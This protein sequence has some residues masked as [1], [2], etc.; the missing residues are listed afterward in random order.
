MGGTQ[1]GNMVWLYNIIQTYGLLDFAKERYSALENNISTWDYNKT[2]ID[3]LKGKQPSWGWMPGCAYDPTRIDYYIDELKDLVPSKENLDM[4]L[5][6]IA[7]VH[8]H[9]SKKKKDV[10]VS[11]S[12]SSDGNGNDDNIIMPFEWMTAYDMRPWTAFP[13]R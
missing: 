6:A 10:V 3:N 4:I 12:I 1:Y 2:K 9:C 7:F 8:N 13:E 11:E 5:H